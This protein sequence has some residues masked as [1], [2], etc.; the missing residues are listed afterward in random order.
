M[1]STYEK[2]ARIALLAVQ[3]AA[4]LT[5]TV[6]AAVDK[7][8][9]S[10][11]DSSP[12]TIADFGAQ[13]LLISAIHH[14][15]PDDGFIG[16][17][18]ADAL[19]DDQELCDRVWDLVRST[20]LEGGTDGEQLLGKLQSKGDMLG[21]IDRGCGAGV[22]TGGRVW[23]LDPIDGTKAF[24]EGSQYAVAL[25]LIEKGQQ[26][27]G[28]LGCPNLKL[29]Q[30][31]GGGGGGGG[32]EVSDSRAVK[33]GL[34]VMLSAVRGQGAYMRILSRGQLSAAR[35]IEKPR[36]TGGAI[37]F[38]ESTQS[39]SGDLERH[40][41]VAAQLGSS[42]PGTEVFALQMRYVAIA[43]GHC[44]VMIRIPRDRGYREPVWDH[45][46]GAL[47]LEE[48]GGRV[49]DLDGNPIDFGAGRRL[50][51]NNGLIAALNDVHAQVLEA[52]QHVLRQGHQ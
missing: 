9:H 32:G 42:W 39:R 15:F 30:G 17:E 16:E 31:G 35:K 13:A 41:M 22:Q 46:G 5:K 25:A 4:I 28:V 18:S 27:V 6:L 47:I 52:V 49:T 29:E 26:R 43:A 1:P 11:E 44:D 10:K 38:V 7:G 2:E 48:S 37:R 24:M 33:D 20:H 19:R 50:H 23:M 12:V 36:R 40:R 21:A 3:R 34:G 45:A 51:K 14:N 8:A